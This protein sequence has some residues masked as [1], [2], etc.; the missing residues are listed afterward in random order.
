MSAYD[1]LCP[2][3]TTHLCSGAP[4]R[5]ALPWRARIGDKTEDVRP[6]FW[7]NRPR[8]YNERTSHWDE[9]PNGRW[10]DSRSPAFGELTDYHLNNIHTGGHPIFLFWGGLGV[11]SQGALMCVC[12][13]GLQATKSTGESRMEPS[14]HRMRMCTGCSP[15][16]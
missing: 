8:S 12:V 9:Y 4:E 7:A 10:G 15:S 6:I 2:H 14:S 11:V 1:Y 16:S 3:T 5:K 13:C